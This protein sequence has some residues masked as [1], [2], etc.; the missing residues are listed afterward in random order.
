MVLTW[1]N[2]AGTVVALWWWWRRRRPRLSLRWG[3]WKSVG[4]KVAAIETL[5]TE[6]NN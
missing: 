6:N 4:A 5:F 2:L 1:R 3:D